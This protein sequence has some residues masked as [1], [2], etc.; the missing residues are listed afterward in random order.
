MTSFTMFLF[1]EITRKVIA[2][3][4]RLKV[5]QSCSFWQSLIKFSLEALVFW[6]MKNWTEFFNHLKKY[7][8]IF[9]WLEIIK[10]FSMFWNPSS[11]PCWYSKV[12]IGIFQ[13]HCWLSSSRLVLNWQ[14]LIPFSPEYTVNDPPF[15]GYE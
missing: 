10:T 9:Q 2:R 8:S 12:T 5:F 6:K 11:C 4:Y 7:Q 3:A 14:S 15:V 1:Y 13:L